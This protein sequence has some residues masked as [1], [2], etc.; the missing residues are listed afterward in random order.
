MKTEA[1]KTSDYTLDNGADLIM[2][3]KATGGFVVLAKWGAEYVTWWASD[4]RLGGGKLDCAHGRYFKEF[5]EAVESFMDR[6]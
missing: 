5:D 4:S 3:K 1:L 2:V 6:D